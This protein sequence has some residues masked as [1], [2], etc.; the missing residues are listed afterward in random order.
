ME[1]RE[2]TITLVDGRT[3]EVASYGDPS[4]HPVFFHHGTPGSTRTLKSIASIAD[5]AQIFLIT[6]SR[7]GYGAST[8]Q[9][10]RDVASVVPDV[11]AVLDFFRVD[12]YV[13]VG[14]SGGGPHALACAAF[15]AP[16]CL[17]AVTLAGV[18]P[19]DVD[20]DWTAGMGEENVKEF[21][22]AREGGPEYEAHLSGVSEVL[23]LADASNVVE[24]F[25]GL[26]SES[27]KAALSSEETRAALA[28]GVGYGVRHDWHGFF[29]DDQTLMKPWGFHTGS[30]E[31]PVDVFYGDHDLMVPPSHGAWL[32][33]RLR[34]GTAH[35]FE[36]DG[37][38]SIFIEHIDEVTAAIQGAFH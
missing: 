3:L 6:T 9:A 4:G 22:L 18:A 31:L 7:P 35:H 14:W 16:R 17:G 19:A 30:I 8:R 28:E 36:P 21:A 25:G 24:L 10:G 11:S 23:A 1:F 12:D 5:R 2:Q 26:L 15:D 38:V 32:L 13:A 27:D 34:H 20:F 29:D 33:E 37:H